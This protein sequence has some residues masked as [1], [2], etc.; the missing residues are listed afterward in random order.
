MT[1]NYLFA[2]GF[3][4]TQPLKSYLNKKPP[5][6]R[7][8]QKNPGIY[9]WERREIKVP[10]GMPTANPNAN[11]AILAEVGISAQSTME[12]DTAIAKNKIAKPI[13]LVFDFIFSP[14]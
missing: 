2:I 3:Q 1:Q 4:V 12:E 13:K 14:F 7:R 6:N 8:R 5:S 11:M 9:L 10:V